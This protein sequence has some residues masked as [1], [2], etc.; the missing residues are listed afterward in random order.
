MQSIAKNVYCGYACVAIKE[1]NEEDFKTFF[2]SSLHINEEYF[3]Q[4][5]GKKSPSKYKKNLK[6]IVAVFHKKWHPQSNKDMYEQT[7]SFENWKSLTTKEKEMHTLAECT[8]CFQ[9]HYD[10]QCTFP[11]APIYTPTLSPIQNKI[12]SENEFIL[13]AIST[14][15]KVCLPAFGRTFLESLTK[16]HHIEKHK[17]KN[18]KRNRKL[19]LYTKDAEMSATKSLRKQHLL[20]Y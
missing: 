15:D 16:S 19:G 10:L 7:F 9:K 1:L 3:L 18:Q 13:A 6:E 11:A 12:S 4:K 5:H 20:H 8:M 17:S 2:Q 14:V